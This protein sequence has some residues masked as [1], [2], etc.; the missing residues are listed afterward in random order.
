[1]RRVFAYAD[2]WS[3]ASHEILA[4][5]GAI[6]GGYDTQTQVEL[7]YGESGYA[8]IPDGGCE[9][10]GRA[11]QVKVTGGQDEDERSCG[12]QTLRESKIVHSRMRAQCWPGDFLHGGP[13]RACAVCLCNCSSFRRGAHSYPRLR[14]FER[15]TAGR[16][17][18]FEKRIRLARYFAHSNRAQLVRAGPRSCVGPEGWT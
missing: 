11:N 7:R 4:R 3:E 5:P 15:E 2:A 8:E 10:S 18:I 12:G 17:G 9:K 13:G 16:V 6:N 1:M 14:G